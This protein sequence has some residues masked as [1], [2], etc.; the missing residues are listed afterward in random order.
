M[1]LNADGFRMVKW[2][3]AGTSGGIWMA[4]RLE[5]WL[6]KSKQSSQ[7]KYHWV[8]FSSVKISSSGLLIVYVC[9][10]IS[11]LYHIKWY[12]HEL[13]CS[14]PSKIVKCVSDFAKVV[15]FWR[16]RYDCVNILW[17]SEQH[18]PCMIYTCKQL[19]I[20]SENK[21]IPLL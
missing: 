20:L 10:F 15:H 14:D 5:D 3:C 6:L 1:C 12:Y 7:I 13:Y 9:L 4:W 19:T 2:C 21:M 11:F 17:E 16:I 8:S 18:K